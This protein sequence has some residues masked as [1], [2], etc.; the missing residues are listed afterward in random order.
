MR[1]VSGEQFGGSAVDNDELFGSVF[2]EQ[3]GKSPGTTVRF[4]DEEFGGG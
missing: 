3:F 1:S 2:V 4:D